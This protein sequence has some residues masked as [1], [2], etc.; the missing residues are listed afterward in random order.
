MKQKQFLFTDGS[1]NP[2]ENI[3]F[4]GYLHVGEN[5]PFKESLKE[6]V[7]LKKL[8]NLNS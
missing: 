6:N 8:L 5:E 3:G 2:Q 4:G 1:V 7:K